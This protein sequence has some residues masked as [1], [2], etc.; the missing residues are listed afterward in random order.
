[1]PNTPHNRE[2]RTRVEQAA[3]VV[4]RVQSLGVR[5]HQASRLKLML[6]TLEKGDI[7]SDDGRYPIALESI[8]DMNQLRLIVDQ[9]EAHRENSKFRASVEKLL[10]DAV[11]PQDGNSN[12]PGRDTQFELYVAAICLRAGM[13]PVDYDEPDIT[14]FVEGTKFGIAAK[15]L[16]TKSTSQL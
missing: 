4:E 7:E 15:R 13:L 14:C 6:R 16:K 8:R 9:M 3:Y 11:L 5:I 10:K 1:M 12:T 2:P